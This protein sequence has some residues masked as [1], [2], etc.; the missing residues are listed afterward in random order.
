MLVL[1]VMPARFGRISTVWR[2][3]PG[4]GVDS[5]QGQV[6]RGAPV[7]VRD[8]GRPPVSGPARHPPYFAR[9]AS[10][11]TVA[12]MMIAPNRYDSSECRSTVRRISL[13]LM[14]VSETWKVAPTVKAR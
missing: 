13:L 1:A 2:S 8:L 14:S 3:R 6:L 7:A 4:S 10:R 12:A 11:F 5:R 9:P